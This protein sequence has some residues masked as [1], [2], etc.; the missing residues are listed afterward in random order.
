M[1]GNATT[2]PCLPGNAVV[3][4]DAPRTGADVS[5]VGRAGGLAPGPSRR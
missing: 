3:A 4:A 2:L 1:T 5:S